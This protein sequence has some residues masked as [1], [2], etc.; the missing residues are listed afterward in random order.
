MD[1]SVMSEEQEEQEESSVS[2][3]TAARLYDG[4]IREI[5]LMQRRRKMM[6]Q[7]SSLG[8]K[9]AMNMLTLLSQ[10]AVTH[11][12]H[13]ALQ[14][15][16][17]ILYLV[18]N[19]TANMKFN[20]VLARVMGDGA[21]E[22]SEEIDQIVS[23]RKPTLFS[24]HVTIS[25]REYINLVLKE[26]VSIVVDFKEEKEEEENEEKEQPEHISVL[27]R[28]LASLAS[29]TSIALMVGK[30]GGLGDVGNLAM[31]LL[32]NNLTLWSRASPL[33]LI[34]CVRCA[35]SI[36]LEYLCVR[37]SGIQQSM[38]EG[39]CYGMALCDGLAND[40]IQ[41]LTREV[42]R[43]MK[44]TED[45]STSSSNDDG[46]RKKRKGKRKGKEEE[47]EEEK[48]GTEEEQP[49][50]CSLF[51]TLRGLEIVTK[52]VCVLL[53]EYAQTGKKSV[54]CVI[55]ADGLSK[56]L[57]DYFTLCVGLLSVIP[58]KKRRV[59]VVSCAKRVCTC[60]VKQSRAILAQSWRDICE[61]SEDDENITFLR[62]G[63]EGVMKHA[64][65]SAK[66]GKNNAKK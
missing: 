5:V 28:S 19:E 12:S 55:S 54:K 3:A 9:R 40:L 10:S 13:T 7:N 53:K 35:V 34:E 44:K 60:R 16:N 63:T 36:C 45:T 26:R 41:M 38:C 11:K 58:V 61:K 25:A 32:K 8:I 39:L 21:E 56:M 50:P 65:Q 64:T 33:L 29:I 46:K 14:F 1:C 51:L 15:L 4:K 6:K 18:H 2:D 17:T 31:Q 42:E 37:G 49:V 24:H 48:E 30:K 62:K 23:Q 57:S 43:R 52:C 20:E 66:R 47:E 27:A 22:I 59:E